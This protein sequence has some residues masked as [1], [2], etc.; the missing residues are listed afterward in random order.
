MAIDKKIIK[1]L[2]RYNSINKY[3]T[4]QE[5]TLPPPPAGD[6]PVTP[7]MGPLPAPEMGATPPTPPV[8]GATPVDIATD[9]DVEKVGEEKDKVKEIDVTE[10]VK[11]QKSVEKKQEDYFESLFQHLNTLETKLGEMDSIVNKLND[12]ESKVEKYRPKSAQEKMDL[13]TI[14]S[15]PFNQKLSDFFQDKQEDFEKTGKNEYILT[16][17]EVENYSPSDIKKSFRSFEDTD[18]QFTQIK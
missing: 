11:S 7:E 10:L 15:G 9:P 1:E 8:T 2:N 16:Q 14:D 17:D 3:I 12:L 4:E 18:N 5:A 6:V 13:R